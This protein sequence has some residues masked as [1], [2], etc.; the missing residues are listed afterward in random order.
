[1]IA[2]DKEKLARICAAVWVCAHAP[3]FITN[4]S[5]RYRVEVDHGAA[6]LAMLFIDAQQIG[7]QIRRDIDS[8]LKPTYR[9]GFVNDYA[10]DAA[11]SKCGLSIDTSTKDAIANATLLLVVAAGLSDDADQFANH[12]V[13]AAQVVQGK[14]QHDYSAQFADARAA[15]IRVLTPTD[16]PPSAETMTA[17]DSQGGISDDMP[18]LTYRDAQQ[19][20]ML[21]RQAQ[22]E[23]LH[24]ASLR[25][26]DKAAE[27][28]SGSQDLHRIDRL[29]REASRAKGGAEAL[30]RAI[31]TI[32]N[33][34]PA[35]LGWF[36]GL[37][38]VEQVLETHPT[39]KRDRYQPAMRQAR[40]FAW[41]APSIGGHIPPVIAGTDAFEICF[42]VPENSGVHPIYGSAGEE[43]ADRI[44]CRIERL[45]D[46]NIEATAGIVR[47]ELRNLDLDHDGRWR[48]SAHYQNGLPLISEA[49]AAQLNDVPCPWCG[50]MQTVPSRT[51]CASLYAGDVFTTLCHGCDQPYQIRIEALHHVY[52]RP[53][54]K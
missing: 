6:G 48:G 35:L 2:T 17:N 12:V 33:M 34:S 8:F 46:G 30:H 26:R 41:G 27:V 13:L 38:Y 32:V 29:D 24:E 54:P 16:A 18:V 19:L 53:V 20:V 3:Q 40:E 23:A 37:R 9:A 4:L 10:I 39:R 51:E 50:D 1:M 31:E 7:T 25:D 44:R 28:D 49:T 36:D 43:V 42:V 52:A 47:V 11:A 5:N 22:I 45:I 21:L 14:A 15:A